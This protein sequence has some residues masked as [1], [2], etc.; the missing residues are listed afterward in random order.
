MFSFGKA[1]I[2]TEVADS[3]SKVVRRLS[4]EVSAISN[5]GKSE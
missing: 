1:D 3:I 5:A 4:Q 2:Q